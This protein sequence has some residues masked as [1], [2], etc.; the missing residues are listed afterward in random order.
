MT[1]DEARAMLTEWRDEVVDTGISDTL[2]FAGFQVPNSGNPS[3][4]LRF[5]DDSHVGLF[6]LWIGSRTY[7]LT[8]RE[9]ASGD[10]RAL[11]DKSFYDDAEPCAAANFIIQFFAGSERPRTEH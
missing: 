3:V 10:H 9:V 6:Q 4:I 7:A 11:V 1:L 5:E 8:I 2:K